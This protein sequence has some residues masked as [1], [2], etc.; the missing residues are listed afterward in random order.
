MTALN[1]NRRMVRTST[2]PDPNQYVKAMTGDYADWV[3][4]EEEAP[5]RRGRWR[6]DVG[7]SADHPVDLEIGTG[8]GYFFQHQALKCP[9]RILL[10]ME[11]K[12]K[13]L[14]QTIKRALSS[15]TQNAFILR[16]HA[17]LLGEVF[18][19]QELNNVFIF[20]PDPWPKKRHWKNRLIQDD[21][22][23]LLHRL[24]RPGSFVELKTDNPEYFDWI[25]ER[26]QRSKYQI[27]RCTR[28]LHTS[29]W[30]GEN[31]QTHFEKLWTSKG[32]KTHMI[33]LK[34]S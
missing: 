1:P 31:F 17:N 6:Q 8:N 26:V 5:Q 3:Y 16:Y 4:T 23:E 15:G 11:L 25:L 18:A 21:F 13:P 22:L 12:Y 2:L 29:E 10:G 7:V 20:F 28:D 32:L 30:A 34:K 33:R 9:D 24:Q 14:I 19:E 27:E